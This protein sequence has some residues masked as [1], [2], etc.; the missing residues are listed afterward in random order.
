MDKYHELTELLQNNGIE[1]RERGDE[2]ELHCLFNDCDADSRGTEAHLYINKHTALYDCKK[3]GEKG[4]LITLK[5]HFGIL[6]VRKSQPKRLPASLDKQV[7]IYHEVLPEDVK[8]YLRSERLLTDQIIDDYQIGYMTERGR[9]WITIPV[10]DRTGSV[11]FIKL[12]QDPF[13]VND[14]QPKYMHTPAGSEAGIF[15]AKILSEK[16]D[17]LVICEGEFDCLVLR[18]FGIPAICSS[19]GA[20]TFKEEWID[21][22]NFVREFYVLMDNDDAGHKGA[23]SLIKKLTVAYPASSILQVTL[24]PEV[25]DGG[26][27]TDYFSKGLGRPDDIF[28]PAGKFVQQAAGVEPI[29]IS[30]FDEITLEDIVKTLSLTIKHDDDNKLVTFLCMLSAYTDSSQL[31]VSF[32]APSSTGKSYTAIEVANL[33][34]VADKIEL[35]GASPTAFFYGEGIYDK[36]RGAKIVSLERKILLFLEQPNTE[37]QARLRPVLSH[38]KRELDHRMTN[39]G[40]KGENRAEP[41]IIRGFPATVFCSAGMRLDEQETTRAILLSPEVTTEKIREGVRRQVQRG[42]DKAADNARIEADPD[43][44]ALKNR[45]LAIKRE[46]VDDIIIPN[47]DEILSRFNERFKKAKPRH[48]RDADHLMSLIKSATLLNVWRRKQPGGLIVASQSDIDQVFEVWGRLIEAQD[49][50]VPPAVMAV[51]KMYIIPGFAEKLSNPEYEEDM[52]KRMVGLSTE[53]LS[54]FYF[55]KEAKPLN[56][57]ILRK[58]ILP[59]LQAS[60]IITRQ[61]PEKGDKRSPHIFPVWY[62]AGEKDPLDPNNDGTRGGYDGLLGGKW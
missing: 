50:N 52:I 54:S 60:G 3:C 22:L 32:N 11:Q 18:R 9:H 8:E 4:N 48:M 21:Q 55:R 27:V 47:P 16:P 44:A 12:R 40:K 6:P 34:P 46:H 51:Y 35:A 5:E 49:M 13:T 62:P 26:D 45:I 38:D 39:K 17:A 14:T 56:A 41:I 43:R 23:E 30:Q 33:F 10:T 24:P 15:N 53:E 20:A 61:K 59:Q 31:N 28:T 57:E 29:D 25:G 19:A 7:A 58:Q 42:A 1:Y 37:L 36:E 2:L